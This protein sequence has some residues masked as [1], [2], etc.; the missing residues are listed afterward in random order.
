[1][2]ETVSPPAATKSKT[3]TTIKTLMVRSDVIFG[4]T[5]DVHEVSGDLRIPQLWS[6]KIPALLGVNRAGR[7]GL[8]PASPI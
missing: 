1:M 6:K 8:W 7:K 2:S 3:A 4:L 5:Y